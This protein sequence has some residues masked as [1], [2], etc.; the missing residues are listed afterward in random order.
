MRVTT[1][2]RHALHEI[3]RAIRVDDGLI[4][5][6]LWPAGKALKAAGLARAS[7]VS[8]QLFR[9]SLTEAGRTAFA[10]SEEDGWD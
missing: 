8:H 5:A 3:D 2:M 10:A 9:W 4:A 6:G 7:R 1:D